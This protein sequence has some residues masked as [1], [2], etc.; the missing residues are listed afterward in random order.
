MGIQGTH[1]SYNA[2]VNEEPVS[3][4]SAPFPQGARPLNEVLR[5]QIAGH[6]GWMGF[7]RFMELA[8][9]APGLGYYARG[10]QQ[11]GALPGSGS[12]FITAPELSPLFG[13][14]L[15]RQVEQALDVTGVAQVWEF[16]AGSGALAAA[17]LR[18]LG[19][20]IEAYCIVE[21]SAALR[22]RQARRLAAQVPEH[23]G[24]VRWVDRLPESI[25]AV[26]VG[27]EVLDAMP[28]ALLAFDGHHWNERGVAVDA[29]GFHWQ[30]RATALRPPHEGPFV[31]G[32]VTELHRHAQAFVA[33]LAK[34]LARG[35]AFFVDYGFPQAEYYHPQR[36]GGTLMCHRA[37]VADTDP[38][39][40]VGE[41][42]ITAHVDFTGVALA[43]QDA[44]MQVL[45]YTSQA[46]FLMNC[47]LLDDLA[48]T[49][50]DAAS[51]AQVAAAQKLV[52]EH[53]MGELFKVIGLAAGEW[54]DAIGFRQGDRTHRL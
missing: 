24:K 25:E 19:D 31:P 3:V 30:D 54:F 50:R 2:R 33:T 40:D 21:L 16:G 27:N 29:Q 47:G 34:A 4:A 12:D 37:H 15:A 6:G 9:Y 10:D 22:E 8:L 42:D 53:E 7:E 46:R 17:L 14:A 39:A 18:A 5:A 44:G 49:P 35:A 11:F 23:A 32:T 43:A 13:R 48:A 51:L 1:D 28:V 38:L 45:G 36:T 26:V 41:K 20:R 52:N